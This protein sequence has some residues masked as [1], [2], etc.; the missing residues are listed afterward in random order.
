MQGTLVTEGATAVKKALNCY[1]KIIQGYAGLPPSQ[2]K[3]ADYVVSHI[4]EVVFFSITELAEASQA[5]ET[6]I[7]RFA[8][9]LGYDG[10]PKF[11]QE[12]VLYFKE[13]MSIEGR[14]RH[15]IEGIPT[16]ADLSYKSITLKEIHWLEQSIQSID[17]A[18]F[19]SAI[20]AICHAQT[21]YVFGNDLNVS[22]ANDLCY[23]LSR[24]KLQAIQQSISGRSVFEKLITI[25]E[26]DLAIIF[27]FYKPSVDFT[28]LA[29]ILKSK[30]VPI[31][32]ITDMLVPPITKAAKIVLFAKQD[33]QEMFY[34]QV[35][36][37]AISNSLVIGV[38]K[39]LGARAVSALKELS[40]MRRQY[41]LNELEEFAL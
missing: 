27:D 38:A 41:N 6:T 19:W 12:L 31:I 14:I 28:R 25:R 1:D 35:V 37:M 26:G 8:R 10:F 21:I 5:S 2:K 11:K 33:S 23:R 13:F 32:L 9:S 20:R 34:S 36:P 22:V 4:N 29:K 18:A 7:V 3:I 24:F 15:S 40:E 17:D 16:R 30:R 39:Q